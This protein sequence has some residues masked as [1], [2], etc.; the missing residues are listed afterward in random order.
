MTLAA[1]PFDN[2]FV[3]E[4]PG[5]PEP[6][7]FRRAVHGACFSRVAPTPVRAPKLL[8]WAREVAALVGLPAD[9]GPDSDEL[10]EVLAGNRVVPGMDPYAACYGGHQFGNWADQLGDGRA[11]T[12]GELRGEGGLRWELQLKGAGPTPYS[13]RGDGRAVLRSSIREFLCSE[14]MHHLGVPTTRALSLVETGDAVV[15]DM[16][17]DGHAKPEPG[18]IVCRVAPSFLRF[19]NFEL[20]TARGEHELLARL[21]DYTIATH[22]PELV[23]ASGQASAQTYAAW[24]AEVCRRTAEMIAHWMRVGFVHGVMNTDNMSILGLTIDYGPYG[25]IDDYDPDWTPNTTDAMRRRYRF[26]NQPRIAVWNLIK[27]ATALQPLVGSGEPF[28]DGIRAF[29]EALDHH[30]RSMF[31]AKLGLEPI[32]ADEDPEDPSSGLGLAS[33]ALRVLGST[34]TDMTIFYRALAEVPLGRE[35]AS[36]DELLAPL[37]PAYYEA[38]PGELPATARSLT[39]AWLRQLGERVRGENLD[40]DRRRA[41]MFAAN[42]K[43]VLRNY[44]AQLAIDRAEAGDPSLV[45]ELLDLMRRPYD[46]QPRHE[47]YA[48]KRPDWA[49]NRP[50]CSTLSCS[51]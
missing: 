45:G 11:I 1:L 28:E 50:G 32:S 30:T 40:P 8:A 43:F 39:L 15:R 9:P 31:A 10:A 21:A 33:A 42:P 47:Q 17:Y 19:G 3:R 13:R 16:F 12:L 37:W 38:E 25:W 27:L 44:L 4:L 34:P 18:A 6:E 46:E 36:D 48:G 41:R 20:L 51:S 29:A 7:N 14:A 23:S 22:F 26:G 49:K 35:Q 2:S 5:D 24:F